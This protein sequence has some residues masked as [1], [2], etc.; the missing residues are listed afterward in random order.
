M[1]CLLVSYFFCKGLF[2]SGVVPALELWQPGSAAGAFVLY[3]CGLILGQACVAFVPRVSA[4]P[5]GNVGAELLFG[6]SL[7]L[8]G[9]TGPA[10]PIALTT[11]RLIEGVGA[12]MG[13]PLMFGA[14]M[15][16]RAFERPERHALALNA[17]FGGGFLTGPLLSPWGLRHVAPTT[18]IASAGGIFLVFSACVFL[19]LWPYL[20]RPAPFEDLPPHEAK[21][22]SSEILVTLGAAK[23]IYGFVMPALGDV[24]GTGQVSINITHAYLWLDLTFVLGQLA[25]ALVLAR[26]PSVSTRRGLSAVLATALLMFAVTHW[27]WLGLVVAVLQSATLGWAAARMSKEPEGVR[28]FARHNL[29]TDPAMALGAGLAHHPWTGLYGLAIVACLPGVWPAPQSRS[30]RA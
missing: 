17:A 7:V 28:S 13:L 16:L 30:S 22:F 27:M 18:F 15:K 20:R 12:G 11:G 26:L 19:L 21:G 14:A 2:A 24:V 3:F 4:T 1:L 29:M 8:I 10:W 23:A 9:M 5:W 6:G 25:C